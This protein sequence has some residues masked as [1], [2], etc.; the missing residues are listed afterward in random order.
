MPDQEIQ[1]LAEWLSP[2]DFGEKYIKTFERCTPGTGA[3]FLEHPKFLAWRRGDS[4]YGTLWC[5]GNPGVGK[6]VLASLVISELGRAIPENTAL[7]FI[8]FE[9]RTRYT[10]SQLTEVILKQLVRW[11][12]TRSSLGS[13]REHK[14]RKHRPTSE[15]LFDILKVEV[16]TRDRVLIVIDALDEADIEVWAP[17]L[18]HLRALHKISLF[19]TSRDTGDIGLRLW[20]YQRL[21]IIVDDGDMRKYVERRLESSSRFK[22]LLE[23]RADVREEI[24]AGVVKRADRMFLLARLHMDFL[25]TKDRVRV[26]D[27]SRA[28]D[29]LPQTLDATYDEAMSRI[30]NDDKA[31]AYRIISWVIHAAQPMTI[32]DLQYALAVQEGMTALDTNDLYDEAYLTSVCVGLIVLQ[33]D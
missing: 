16:E 11:R 33:E 31:L 21:D 19:A 13:L 24:V 1:D 5:P 7:V 14:A 3:W 10:V 15:E 22:Q 29:E 26:K 28:L 32:R 25:E 4:G 6:S 8:Y 30:N 20:P 23:I 9:Y 18:G 2:L 17:L 27:L 12:I